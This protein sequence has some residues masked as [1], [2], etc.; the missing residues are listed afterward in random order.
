[1]TRIVGTATISSGLGSKAIYLGVNATYVEITTSK[2]YSGDAW[3][4]KS[5]GKWD[6]GYQYVVSIMAD[7]T[8]GQTELTNDKVIRHYEKVGG[9]WTVVYEAYVVSTGSGYL[10]LY[11]TVD[12]NSDDYPILIDAEY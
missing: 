8:N 5:V 9:V 11:V 12:T 6:G 3:A 1:M 7:G 10:N 2:K 4:H